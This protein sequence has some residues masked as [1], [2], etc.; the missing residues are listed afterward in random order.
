MSYAFLGLAIFGL[1]TSSVFA[2]MVL[3]AVPGYLREGK[4]ARAAESDF[5][6]PLTLLK[7]VHGAEP[8]LDVHLASFFEQDYPRYEILFCARTEDDA[9]LQ[10]ARRVAA[11]YPQI[12]SRFL[13]TGGQPDYINAKVASMERMETVASHEILVISDSDVRVT[14]DYLRAVALPFADPSVGAMTC[15]YRGVAAEGGLWARLEA[16]GMSVEMTAGVLVARSLEGMQFVLGPTMAFRREAIRKMGGFKITAD[17]CA[18]DFVLGNETFK[19]GQTVVLS[20]H[21]IDHMVINSTF[22]AS[23]KHQVR[24][25]KSTR[26]SR[27][28]GHFGTALTFSMPFGLLGLAAAALA[29]HPVWG[30]ALLGWAVSTRLAISIAV[31]RMVVRDTSWFGLLVL[32]PIRDLMGFGFWVASYFGST[33]V[34]RGKLFQLL[35]MGKMRA[36]R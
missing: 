16:V 6:P 25:M 27:P 23:M 13:V 33:I 4:A 9:G 32:Y 14:P 28:K 17:Y 10:T 29:G 15:P 5:T 8:N 12:P 24:W 1:I 22:A 30:C 34:W 11:R 31:G 35:P 20:H 18:D 3:R 19:L 7:P 36:V 21:A 26:F 2:A